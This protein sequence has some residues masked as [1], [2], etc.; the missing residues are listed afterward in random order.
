MYFMGKYCFCSDKSIVCSN[1]FEVRI[2][3][4]PATLGSWHLE[5]AEHFR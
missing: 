2:G 3:E 4:V 5:P 1:D